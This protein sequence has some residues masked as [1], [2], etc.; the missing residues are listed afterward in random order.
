MSETAT[1]PQVTSTG[2][3][4]FG[5]RRFYVDGSEVVTIAEDGRLW[6]CHPDHRSEWRGVSERKIGDHIDGCGYI[7]S[8]AQFHV[9]LTRALGTGHY[10]KSLPAALETAQRL[11]E[12][13]TRCSKPVACRLCKLPKRHNGPCEPWS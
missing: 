10:C 13:Y 2:P 5:Y 3:D 12:G 11:A 1:A 8:G 9:Y 7:A 6:R 4:A